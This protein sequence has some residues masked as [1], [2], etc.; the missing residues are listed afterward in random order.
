MDAPEPT[1]RELEL[2]EVLWRR[3]EASV[4]E[5]YEELRDDIPIVQAT[6]Q[7]FLRTMTKKGLVSYRERGRSFVY[8]ALV[9]P[10]PTRRLLLNRVLQRVYDGAIDQLVEGAIRLK[11]PSDT[12]LA[13]LRE[14]IAELEEESQQRGR[15]T[16]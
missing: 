15:G 13:R 5:I 1:D 10:E 12:E 6:V 3:G 16:E 11:Q 8:R 2:L 9:K 7:A 4:R 14:L